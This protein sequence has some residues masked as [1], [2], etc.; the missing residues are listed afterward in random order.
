[1]KHVGPQISHIA[2]SLT[3]SFLL[4]REDHNEYEGDWLVRCEFLLLAQTEIGHTSSTC[5]STMYSYQR[6]GH[7]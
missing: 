4:A 3:L 1:M 2:T 6:T 5:E 7:H